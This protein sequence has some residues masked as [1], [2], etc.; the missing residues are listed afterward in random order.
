MKILTILL[1]LTICARIYY[2]INYS[3]SQ[4]TI[5]YDLTR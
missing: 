3:K 2:D 1:A 5:C 4:E